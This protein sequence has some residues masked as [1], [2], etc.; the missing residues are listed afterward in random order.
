ML[1][2]ITLGEISYIPFLRSAIVV[3]F[4][5]EAISRFA[6][7]R[8]VKKSVYCATVAALRGMLS[9]VNRK[10]RKFTILG[11]EGEKGSLPNL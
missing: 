11:I 3:L 4:F 8:W 2:L 1:C 10:V 5:K 6:G 7:K 9:S